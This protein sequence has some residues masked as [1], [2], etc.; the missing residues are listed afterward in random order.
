MVDDLRTL[1]RNPIALGP[2]TMRGTCS[3]EEA[4]ARRRS[5]RAF[6]SDPL[7]LA[8]L[9]QVC[10]AAQGVTAPWNGR[11]APSAGATY[12]V[13]VYAAIGAVVGLDAGLYRYVPYGHR[14]EHVRPADVR[15]E[16]TTAALGQDAIASAPV[17]LVITAVITA[18]ARRYGARATRFAH[19]E[20]G[21]VAQNVALEAVALSLGT[22]PIGAFDDAEVAGI[23]TC[24]RT[25]LALY[26]LPLGRPQPK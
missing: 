10:W 11:T 20:A 12:P 15:A 9:G 7:T 16:L 5:V 2:P 23:L 22:V 6:R 21:H 18:I 13:R 4:L 26:I 14:L 17:S 3:V 8:E 24:A 25:E 1:D 19:L